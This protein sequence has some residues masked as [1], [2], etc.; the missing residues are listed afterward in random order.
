MRVLSHPLSLTH[1]TPFTL[2]YHLQETVE[3]LHDARVE[4]LM[5]F[6]KVVGEKR[7]AV[8]DT[9]WQT[10]TGGHMIA[11]LPGATPTKPGSATLPFFGVVPTLLDA[12]GQEIEGVGEGS[13][14]SSWECSLCEQ[15]QQTDFFYQNSLRACLFRM[16]VVSV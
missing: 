3:Y 8:V 1:K 15:P 10:E 4:S 7:C 16:T 11:P 12:S 5:A 14:V 6:F 2:S 13:L 9:Y